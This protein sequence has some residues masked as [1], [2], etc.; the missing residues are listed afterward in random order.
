MSHQ[1][2]NL[3]ISNYIVSENVTRVAVFYITHGDEQVNRESCALLYV[4]SFERAQ[5][6]W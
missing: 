4:D 6:L 1:A 2:D 5:A 3:T